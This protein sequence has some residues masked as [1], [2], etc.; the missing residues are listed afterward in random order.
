MIL[1]IGWVWQP[2]FN[3]LERTV[4]NLF[5]SS[6]NITITV[7]REIPFIMLK[8]RRKVNLLPKAGL[9]VTRTLREKR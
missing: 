5:F 2:E 6:G 3:Q 9:D 8:W 4:F 7:W 1:M